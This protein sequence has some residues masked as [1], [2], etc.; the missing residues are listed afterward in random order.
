MRELACRRKRKN[1][2]QTRPPVLAQAKNGRPV[3]ANGSSTAFTAKAISLQPFWSGLDNCFVPREIVGKAATTWG[4]A[5]S[6]INKSDWKKSC[7]TFLSGYL[8]APAIVVRK[9]TRV[10]MEDV[11]DARVE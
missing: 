4:N 3:P 8:D 10:E 6:I 5:Q 9:S 7:V 11:L 1:H 2:A